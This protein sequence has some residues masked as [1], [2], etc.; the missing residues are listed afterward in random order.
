MRAV[1]LAFA[2]TVAATPAGAQQASPAGTQTFA[3]GAFL[4]DSCT[5]SDQQAQAYCLAYISGTVDGFTTLQAT[6]GSRGTPPVYC[7]PPAGQGHLVQIQGAVIGTLRTDARARAANAASVV[8]EVLARTFP[9]AS[10]RR[11]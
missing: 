11:N 3:N 1:I 5:R 10:Q 7:P 8:I 4:L 6:L 9:C 2:V